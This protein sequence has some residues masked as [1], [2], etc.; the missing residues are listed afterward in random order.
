MKTKVSETQAGS[1]RKSK[2]KSKELILWEALDRMCQSPEYQEHL[3]PILI[4]AQ[5][6]KWLDPDQLDKQGKP[7]FPNLKAFHKAYAESYGK[8]KAFGEIQTM[9]DGASAMIK[10]LA[11]VESKKTAYEF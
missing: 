2:L 8:A 5:I 11:N 1:S 10:S 4:N 9:I 3:K 7:I 6:N